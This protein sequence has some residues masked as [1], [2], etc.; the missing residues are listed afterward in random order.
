VEVHLRLLGLRSFVREVLM[1]TFT[2][3]FI[4]CTGSTSSDVRSKR[5]G[6]CL[7]LSLWLLVAPR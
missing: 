5:V 1:R 2:F 4:L 3:G 6:C 7:V